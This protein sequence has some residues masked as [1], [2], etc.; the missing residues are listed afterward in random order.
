MST[1]INDHTSYSYVV[2]VSDYNN[3]DCTLNSVMFHEHQAK[4]YCEYMNTKAEKSI[5][6]SYERAINRVWP[7]EGF[8]GE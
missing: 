5:K 1:N 2:Y 4:A 3:G 8:Y 6:Y 7:I